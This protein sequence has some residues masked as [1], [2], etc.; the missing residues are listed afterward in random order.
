MFD[1]IVN[2]LS[3]S[4]LNNLSFRI[5]LLGISTKSFFSLANLL[6]AHKHLIVKLYF[7]QF[8]KEYLSFLPQIVCSNK[9]LKA[10]CIT[11]SFFDI[12]CIEP[13]SEG[14]DWLESCKSLHLQ[15]LGLSFCK[16]DSNG[17]EKIGK[18]LSLNNS[19]LHN[20]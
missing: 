9:V 6:K 3:L 17:V 7:E 16:L 14:A 12:E 11:L 5:L 18:M 20:Y 19:I 1:V 8:G 2:S 10:L 13:I 15:Q 4:S